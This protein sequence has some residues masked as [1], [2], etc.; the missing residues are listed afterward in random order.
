MVTEG[1]GEEV[2]EAEVNSI[3][4]TNNENFVQLLGFCNKGQHRLLV[5]KH[6]K[7]GLIAHL[8][9]KYSRLRWSKRVQVAN[10]TA[11][12]LCYLHEECST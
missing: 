7:T 3:S 2:F 8:L 9:F 12:G 11:K 1:E 5:Y 6:M 10:N 4:R